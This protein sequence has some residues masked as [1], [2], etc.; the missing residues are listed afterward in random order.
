MAVQ[1][2]EDAL[3]LSLETLQQEH[4]QLT[5]ERDSLVALRA[6]S[7]HQAAALQE[8]ARRTTN[9]PRTTPAT[10]APYRLDHAPYNFTLHIQQLRLLS[11]AKAVTDHRLTGEQEAVRTTVDMLTKQTAAHEAQ[12]EVWEHDTAEHARTKQRA[13]SLELELE[14]CGAQIRA[15]MAKL[16]DAQVLNEAVVS[17]QEALAG[18]REREQKAKHDLAPL[19][20]ER[21]LLKTKNLTLRDQLAPPPHTY[22]QFGSWVWSHTVWQYID[23]LRNHQEHTNKLT[24]SKVGFSYFLTFCV[25]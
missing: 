3:I 24:N 16:A 8:Q 12:E 4:A 22:I 20:A 13:Q 25:V 10:H 21:D 9:S 11:T 14:L 19:Q 1:T 18:A 15:Q 2:P 17:L 7:E 5:S 23:L 6:A